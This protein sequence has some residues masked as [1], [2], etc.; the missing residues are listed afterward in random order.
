MDL[1][2]FNRIFWACLSNAI[3]GKQKTMLI[4]DINNRYHWV[5]LLFLTLI[6]VM[7]I[8]TTGKHSIKLREKSDIYRQSKLKSLGKFN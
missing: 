6:L 3:H 1:I 8:L 5:Y 2:S 7:H 4:I